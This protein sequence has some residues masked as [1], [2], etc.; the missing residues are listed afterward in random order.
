VVLGH[1]SVVGV[2]RYDGKDLVEEC[3]LSRLAAGVLVEVHSSQIFGDDNRRDRDVGVIWDGGMSDHGAFTAGSPQRST[4][5]RRNA[6]AHV[7]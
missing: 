1:R 3:P 7:P 2:D 4:W 6:K 5:R